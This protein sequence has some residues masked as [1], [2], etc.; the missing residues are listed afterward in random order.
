[1]YCKTCGKE[2]NDGAVVCPNCGCSTN[3]KPIAQA[4][5]ESRN[6]LGVL[7]GFFAGLIG[8]V[9]GLAMFQS[10]TEERET[11]IKGWVKG[12]IITF[13]ISVVFG[14][15]YGVSISYLMYY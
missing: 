14:I 1:M 10:G 2:I 5:G 12:F 7:L 15:I 4:G 3:N 6:G 13:C 9:I 8:L 11:F